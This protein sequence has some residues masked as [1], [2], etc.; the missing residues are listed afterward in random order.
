MKILVLGNGVLANSLVTSALLHGHQAFSVSTR[1]DFD[2]GEF[3]PMSDFD[4][5]ID[6]MDLPHDN[7]KGFWHLQNRLTSIRKKLSLSSFSGK[8][9]Y[10]SSTNLYRPSFASIDE[11]SSVLSADD[12][13]KSPYL[14]NKINSEALLTSLFSDR[15][16]ILRLV[17]LWSNF[18]EPAKKSFFGDLI[19]ARSL[20]ET[21]A[22]RTGDSEVISFMNYSDA[23]MLILKIFSLLPPEVRICNISASCWSSREL[24]KSPSLC[25]NLSF[26]LGRR[27]TSM[28]YTPELLNCAFSKLP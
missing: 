20:G 24:L 21:L 8:Y 4:I 7:H 23:A 6:T 13:N 19:C 12:I 22:P 3:E 5:A 28:H 2:L 26:S 17:S 25:A 16:L 18:V 1:A 14:L 10:I 9:C 27:I 15:L 11:S